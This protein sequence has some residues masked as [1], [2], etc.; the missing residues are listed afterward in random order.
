M[1]CFAK[2]TL[3]DSTNPIELKTMSFDQSGSAD[4]RVDFL[5]LDLG[6]SVDRNNFF[7]LQVLSSYLFYA[8]NLLY[9]LFIVYIIFMIHIA[10]S[11]SLS[12][13]SAIV[14]LDEIEY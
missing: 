11:N 1:T 2:Y 14:P 8:Y 13:L 4:R 6:I 5:F 3:E 12:R 10:L 9:I 7:Y